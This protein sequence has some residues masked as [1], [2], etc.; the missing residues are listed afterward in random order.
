MSPARL[1]HRFVKAEE[2]PTAV[3]GHGQW[4]Q[5]G[6]GATALPRVPRFVLLAQTGGDV[7]N[8]G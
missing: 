6:A 5:I 3:Y 7:P 1:P 2:Q 4:Q 8:V